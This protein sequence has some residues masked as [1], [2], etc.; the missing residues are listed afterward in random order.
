MIGA[1]GF[2]VVGQH[3][4]RNPVARAIARQRM[5]TSVRDFS[6]RLHLLA[7]GELV[8]ADGVASAK[9]LMVAFE[10][11]H[12]GGLEHSPQA[13]VIRG[14]ISTLEQLALR[15]WRWRTQDATAIDAGLQRAQAVA[16]AASAV[17]MQRAWHAVDRIEAHIAANQASLEH[18]ACLN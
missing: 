11:L 6:I 4:A 9:V 13:S 8:R 17:D 3:M 12:A 1:P 10:V 15:G 2:L 16:T 7:D 18:T 14:A 5:A